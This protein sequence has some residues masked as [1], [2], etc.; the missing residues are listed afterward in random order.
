MQP[1]YLDGRNALRAAVQP[2]LAEDAKGDVSAATRK[3]IDEAVA[4][5]RARFIEATPDFDPGYQ[6]SLAYLTTLASLS[7]CCTIPA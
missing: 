2:A 4:H 3:R 5:F 7:G 6:D 1:T